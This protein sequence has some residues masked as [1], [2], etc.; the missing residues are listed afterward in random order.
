MTGLEVLALGL[1]K[2]VGLVE[3]VSLRISRMFFDT[4]N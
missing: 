4:L 2:M 1:E 3:W